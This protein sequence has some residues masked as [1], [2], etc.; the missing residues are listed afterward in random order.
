MAAN[1]TTVVAVIA[2]Y[3]SGLCLYYYRKTLGFS[4]EGLLLFR[5][6]IAAS[7]MVLLVPGIRFA[8]WAALLMSFWRQFQCS[9]LASNVLLLL[10]L[11]LFLPG[12]FPA[13]LFVHTP[14]KYIEI[15]ANCSL[16]LVSIDFARQF[17]IVLQM[18][19][20]V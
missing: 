3:V 13:L 14:L 16:L 17:G 9:W 18:G 5:L 2:M 15:N 19:C 6:A 1:C 20:P 8:M 7:N 11:L 10:R 12:A 4:A